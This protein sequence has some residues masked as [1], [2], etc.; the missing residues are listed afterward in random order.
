M[1]NT[2]T[3]RLLRAASKHCPPDLQRKIADEL[4]PQPQET[5]DMEAL[6]ACLVDAI[7]ARDFDDAEHYVDRIHNLRIQQA[8]NQQ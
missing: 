4:G 8:D 5:L 7:D 6:R 1:N 2:T 3:R